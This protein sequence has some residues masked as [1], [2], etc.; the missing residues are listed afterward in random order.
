MKTIAVLGSTGSIGRQTLDVVRAFPD[1]FKVDALVAGR[2]V[3]LLQSQIWEF[4]PRFVFSTNAESLGSLPP[5][6]KFI[7]EISEIVAHPSV[8]L[9]VQGMVG[10][11]NMPARI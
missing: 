8:D 2:N 4:R 1:V 11:V 5:G 9:V 10:N 3:E 7:D 6:T